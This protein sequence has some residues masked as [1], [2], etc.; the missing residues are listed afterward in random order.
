MG[1]VGHKDE[2]LYGIFFRATDWAF[3][4]HDVSV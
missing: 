1:W 3:E 4:K 2:R